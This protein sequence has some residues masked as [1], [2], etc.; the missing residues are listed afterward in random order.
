M[1]GNSTDDS[2]NIAACFEL[3]NSATDSDKVDNTVS[4]VTIHSGC[5]GPP[6]KATY[7]GKSE[8]FWQVAPECETTWEK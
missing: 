5:K 7:A 1:F 8:E 6:L 3:D 2:D 4:R